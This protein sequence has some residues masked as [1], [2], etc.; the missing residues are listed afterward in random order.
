MYHFY[1]GSLWLS[2]G[3]YGCNFRGPVCQNWEIAHAD[4]EKEAKR[5][6]L[7]SPEELIRIALKEGCKGIP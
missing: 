2:L 5:E 7:I 3:S 1:P 6:R 4:V